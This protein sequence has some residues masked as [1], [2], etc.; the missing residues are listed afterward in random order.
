M[1]LINTQKAHSFGQDLLNY[2]DNGSILRVVKIEDN[3][4]TYELTDGN[5]YHVYIT[6]YTVYMPARSKS[7]A[8]EYALH[9]LEDEHLSLRLLKFMKERFG[10]EYVKRYEEWINKKYQ[11][12]LPDN[13][14]LTKLRNEE[15]SRK[16]HYMENLLGLIYSEDVEGQ[17]M[18]AARCEKEETKIRENYTRLYEHTKKEQREDAENFKKRHD[19]R[20]A[21][22]KA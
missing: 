13:A 4:L 6:D 17:N 1:E 9:H 2:L 15:I 20:L 19:E 7:A 18:L 16:V 12:L 22:L 21:K 5:L 3:I 14:L 8:F 11:S 10:E